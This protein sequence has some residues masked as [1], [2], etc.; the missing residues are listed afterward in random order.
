[1]ELAASASIGHGPSRA[2]APKRYRAFDVSQPP[3]DASTSLSTRPILA[4]SIGGLMANEG[5]PGLLELL[6]CPVGRD[7]LHAKDGHL[8]SVTLRRYPVR[9]GSPVLLSSS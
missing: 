8:V 1:M 4:Q 6:C 7:R 2:R 3:C 9:D 5:P